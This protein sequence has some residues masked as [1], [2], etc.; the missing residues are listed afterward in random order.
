MKQTQSTILCQDLNRVF[1][2]SFVVY[3]QWMLMI[4]SY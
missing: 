3:I 2:L 4:M 1:Q